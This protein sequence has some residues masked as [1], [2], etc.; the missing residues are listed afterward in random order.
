MSH[1]ASL[2]D[3]SGSVLMREQNTS[4]SSRLV[5]LLS[6]PLGPLL[7]SVLLFRWRF[8]ILVQNYQVLADSPMFLFGFFL[9]YFNF[10]LPIM[11]QQKDKNLAVLANLWI[12]RVSER[13]VTWAEVLKPCGSRDERAQLCLFVD[14][15][16]SRVTVEPL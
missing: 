9:P 16:I 10:Q 11:T 7:I 14:Y 2:S 15:E 4:F 3:D 5:P 6:L 1:F 13:I 12:H 8:P